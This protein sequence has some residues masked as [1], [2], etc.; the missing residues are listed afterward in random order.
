[1]QLLTILA[2]ISAVRI[3]AAQVE[4]NLYVSRVIVLGVRLT[5][6]ANLSGVRIRGL[7]SGDC[8]PRSAV[9]DPA[10]SPGCL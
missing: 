4:V 7:P 9:D 2:V 1:M 8:R 3:Q 6:G 5:I 10:L